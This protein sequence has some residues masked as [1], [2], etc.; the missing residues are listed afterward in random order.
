M[1]PPPNTYIP[2]SLELNRNVPPDCRVPQI[3]K[4][5]SPPILLSS[6]PWGRLFHKL[7]DRYALPIS[8]ASLLIRS[9]KSCHSSNGEFSLK[10]ETLGQLYVSAFEHGMKSVFYEA[11]IAGMG[12]GVGSTRGGVSLKCHGYS[13]KLGEFCG[14]VL[15]R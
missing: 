10:R 14:D 1:L 11:G 8:Y 3:S 5:C 6:A 7:D 13:D 4:P 15:R 2:S 9:P 12:Y